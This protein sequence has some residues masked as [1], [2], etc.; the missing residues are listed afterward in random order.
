MRIYFSLSSRYLCW[1]LLTLLPFLLSSNSLWRPKFVLKKF[2]RSPSVDTSPI[3]L[4]IGFSS[5]IFSTVYSL[6]SFNSS[7]I[8]W[9]SKYP[10]SLSDSIQFNS[11]F[12][13][14]IQSSSISSSVN[15]CF[16]SLIIT[17]LYSS[18]SLPVLLSF[19]DLICAKALVTALLL[20]S[21]T[22]STNLLDQKSS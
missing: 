7:V 15:R 18:T 16:I 17:Q 5:L 13:E 19:L 22:P 14:R 10:M 1:A 2:I 6:S 8:I 12:L 20:K 9:A 21:L 3:L 4:L 11:W